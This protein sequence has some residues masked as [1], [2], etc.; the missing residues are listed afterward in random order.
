LRDA[1]E[2]QWPWYGTLTLDGECILVIPHKKAH[3]LT[4]GF[5]HIGDARAEQVV[6][7]IRTSPT[8][9]PRNAAETRLDYI[10]PIALAYIKHDDA[11]LVLHRDASDRSDALRGRDVVW[12]G[13]HINL[14]DAVGPA[15]GQTDPDAISKGLRRE[16]YEELPALP[17]NLRPELV[18]IVADDST[19]RSRIHLG[20]VHRVRIEDAW[21]ASVIA[22]GGDGV[23]RVA[24]MPI[25]ELPTRLDRLEPWSQSIVTEH[26]NSDHEEAVLTIAQR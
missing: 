21:R 10:Q 12:V 18:G 15:P 25:A 13:G 14:D 17:R 19:E 2:C 6:R 23:P 22:T 9:L 7:V 1:I 16:L 5:L 20:L 4:S 26:L 24:F 3:L 11:L 8:F